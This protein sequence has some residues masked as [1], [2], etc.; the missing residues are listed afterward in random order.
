[1]HSP[2]YKVALLTVLLLA[3]CASV[4]P[5]PQKVLPPL[6]LLQD[7]PQ[8]EIRKQTNGDLSWTIQALIEV[9]KGCNLDKKNLREWAS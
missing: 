8:P 3:S 6:E 1:M 7:C 9:L 4:A 2:D 5:G